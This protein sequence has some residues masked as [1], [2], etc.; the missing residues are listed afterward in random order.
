MKVIAFILYV[1]FFFVSL[2]TVGSDTHDDIP[3]ML[4]SEKFGSIVLP[5]PC[6][7]QM[8]LLEK[9]IIRKQPHQYV[10]AQIFSQ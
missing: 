8:M 5:V 10:N 3:C 9:A 2:I 7:T 6:M 4:W 1:N